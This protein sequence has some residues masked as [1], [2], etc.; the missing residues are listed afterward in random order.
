M[1]ITKR[2][3]VHVMSKRRIFAVYLPI[4]WLLKPFL[5]FLQLS[6]IHEGDDI[7]DPFMTKYST[8]SFLSWATLDSFSHIFSLLFLTALFS[9]LDSPPP[10][11]FKRYLSIEVQSFNS[12]PLPSPSLT[13]SLL[14]SPLPSHP[15]LSSPISCFLS[16]PILFPDPW[17][18]HVC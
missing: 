4:L 1:Q 3:R 6:T 17:F 12:P 18:P 7:V 8:I 5:L 10:Q 9:S 2:Q 14:P 15:L 16:S 11:S 13:S